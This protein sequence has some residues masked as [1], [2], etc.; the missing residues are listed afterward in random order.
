MQSTTSLHIERE[1]K[2][3]SFEKP[4]QEE[5][6]TKDRVEH[7]INAQLH[8]LE[9]LSFIPA[10]ELVDALENDPFFLAPRDF[11]SSDVLAVDLGTNDFCVFDQET[12]SGGVTETPPKTFYGPPPR[13]G[14][15]DRWEVIFWDNS[16]RG[17]DKLG[18]MFRRKV[19]FI[20]HDLAQGRFP[21]TPAMVL[22]KSRCLSPVYKIK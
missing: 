20:V 14:A 3:E 13:L 11:V 8:G 5:S 7:S 17:L 10:I 2:E 22:Q 15:D 6:K 18:P 1:R 19:A 4:E 16:L 12:V 21:P 9:Q